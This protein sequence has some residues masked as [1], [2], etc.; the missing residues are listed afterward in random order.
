ML[1]ISL[2]QSLRGLP[3]FKEESFVQT[4]EAGSS[5][6]S[7]RINDRKLPNIDQLMNREHPEGASNDF[8]PV[9]SGPVPWSRHG[10]YLNSRPSFTFDPYFHAGAYYVQEASSMFIGQALSQ[11]VDLSQDLTVLDL[12]AAPGGKSTLLQSMITPGSLL[13]S[14]EVIRQRANILE[15]NLIKW[16]GSNVIVTNNDPKDFSRLEGFFDVMMVDAPCSGSGLFRRDEEA[17]KEWSEANVLLCSQRQQRILADA[18]PG[19][20]QGGVLIYATCSFSKEEDEDIMDWILQ[21]LEA[22]PVRLTLEEDWGIT[23]TISEGKGYGYRFW[24]DRVKGEGFFVSVFRKTDGA[25]FRSGNK[26]AR[27]ETAGQK[28]QEYIRP[29]LNDTA[30]HHKIFKLSDLL[31]ALPAKQENELAALLAASLYIRMSGCRLGK[32]AGKDLIPDHSLALSSLA[33]P[34]LVAITLKYEQAIQYL[35]KDEVQFKGD[36]FPDLPKGWA[37]ARYE[38]INLGWVKLLSNRLNNYYPKEWRILK[39]A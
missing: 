32:L 26:K 34:G 36:S 3:G 10:Y 27:L 1:P 20:K 30:T 29:W 22:E 12:C 19:L 16:G 14:N 37:L 5:L 11:S 4:H 2:I 8:I 24:P 33:H 25:V 9:I 21:N 38:G 39:K 35:R 23:E 7:I 18:W 28:E 31:F 15:E 13:V 17:V 6:V